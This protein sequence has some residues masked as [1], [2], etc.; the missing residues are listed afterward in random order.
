M[1]TPPERVVFLS[2][3][4]MGDPFLPRTSCMDM[5]PRAWLTMVVV[6]GDDIL[7]GQGPVERIVA[8]R[9]RQKQEKGKKARKWSKRG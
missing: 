5:R 6:D 8:S 3:F 2:F 1:W 7:P 9:R 4:E